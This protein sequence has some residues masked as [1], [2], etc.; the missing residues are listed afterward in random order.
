MSNDRFK[1]ESLEDS[2][3]IVKYLNALRDGFSSGTLTFVSDDKKLV[4]R[5][6]GLINLDVDA[7]RKGDEIKLS[8]K[9]RWA[10]DVRPTEI[11]S[12]A[13]IIEPEDKE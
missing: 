10:E 9:M 12:T 3:T 5:P 1:H 11:K 13:L 6:R 2:E 8:V 7:K 4:V